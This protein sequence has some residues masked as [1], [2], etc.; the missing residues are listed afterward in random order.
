MNEMI[1]V[2]EVRG[3]TEVYKKGGSLHID[4]NEMQLKYLKATDVT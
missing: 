3:G 1:R 4:G 2:H